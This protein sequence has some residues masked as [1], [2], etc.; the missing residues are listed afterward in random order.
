[1][2]D[3]YEAFDRLERKCFNEFGARIHGPDC[4]YRLVLASVCR[5]R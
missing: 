5:A 4:V 1:M 3:M 2:G